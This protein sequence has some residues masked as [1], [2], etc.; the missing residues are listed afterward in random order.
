MGV[1]EC[2]KEHETQLDVLVSYTAAILVSINVDKD[3]GRDPQ[4]LGHFLK[5]WI[6]IFVAQRSG[7]S[8]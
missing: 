1:K 6:A 5:K 8:S 2:C 7:P 4:A 3:G